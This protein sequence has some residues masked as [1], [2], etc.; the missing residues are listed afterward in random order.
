ME[1]SE[2]CC[3]RSECGDFWHLKLSYKACSYFLYVSTD[4]MCIYGSRTKLRGWLTQPRVF[5][6]CVLGK[7]SLVRVERA[8]STYITQSKQRQFCAKH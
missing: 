6:E 5:V 2:S 3:Y 1:G 8:I 7:M 4:R